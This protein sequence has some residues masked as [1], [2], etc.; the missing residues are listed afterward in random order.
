MP[1]FCANITWLFDDLPLPDRV[2][3]AKEAGFEAVE[4]LSPYDCDAAELRYA[5]GLHEMP[6]AL[7]NC[8]PP[9]YADPE[10]PRGFAAVPEEE[11]R[12]ANALRRAL[13]YAGTLGAQRLHIMSGAAEGQEAEDCLVRN[14]THAAEAA[15]GLP[16][17]IEVIN[18][19]DMPGY[20]L[21][22][23]DT[24]LRVLDRVGSDW[25]GLQFDIY[26]AQRITGDVLATW[27][28][29]KDRVTHVQF[30]DVPG[31][32]GPGTGQLDLPA[33]WAQMA[34]DGYDGW[35]SAEYKPDGPTEE[36]LDWLS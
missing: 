1:R 36:G 34:A 29:V 30:A 11:G 26:H 7:I 8:P 6:L 25:I 22:D 15:K 13:R 19:H 21:R 12:F 27:A 16:L 23:Y 31:R 2:G 14:L 9:N 24:A 28:A 33:I 20:F 35:I 4:I 10:G 32:G 18:T 17:T 5:L 3:A